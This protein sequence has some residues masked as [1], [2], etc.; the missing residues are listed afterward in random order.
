MVRRHRASKEGDSLI[1][2]ELLSARLSLQKQTVLG[3]VMVLAALFIMPL[4][5]RPL[6][7]LSG[8]CQPAPASL[9]VSLEPTFGQIGLQTGSLCC[10][11]LWC[12]PADLRFRGGRSFNSTSALLTLHHTPR[13]RLGPTQT[14]PRRKN[15]RCGELDQSSSSSGFHC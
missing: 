9:G 2:F 14:P 3:P 15:S 12:G 6:A 4:F 13:M 8:T 7:G 10:A 5:A 1:P 11:P